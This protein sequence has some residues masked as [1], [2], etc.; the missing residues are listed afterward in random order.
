MGRVLDEAL[1]GNDMLV[2]WFVPESSKRTGRSKLRP[3]I[4]A[5]WSPLAEQELGPASDVRLPP[6]LVPVQTVLAGSVEL[7]TEGCIPF[8]VFD[9]LQKKHAIDVSGMALSRTRR[10][11]LYRAHLLMQGR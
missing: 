6:V 4:F 1:Q 8:E 9:E 7:D 3:D 5:A 10:G 2:E 11:D